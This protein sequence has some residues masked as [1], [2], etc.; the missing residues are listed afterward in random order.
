MP[1]WKEV[2]THRF[3]AHTYTHRAAV[4]YVAKQHGKTKTFQPTLWSTASY[5]AA[6][7]YHLEPGFLS[8]IIQVIYWM[9]DTEKSKLCSVPFA[10][11]ITKIPFSPK[12]FH[13]AAENCSQDSTFASPASS[14]STD[15]PS[16]EYFLF[17]SHIDIANKLLCFFFNFSAWHKSYLWWR[18]DI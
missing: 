13:W 12:A 3:H 2:N 5:Y 14:F 15:K 4:D 9:E 1:Q 6:M 16:W 18:L 7:K 10:C 8:K 11:A 17:L